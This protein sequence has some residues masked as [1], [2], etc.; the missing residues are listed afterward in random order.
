MPTSPSSFAPSLNHWYVGSGQASPSHVS[1]IRG[2]ISLSWGPGSMKTDRG[3]VTT[4]GVYSFA[5]SHRMPDS[6]TPSDELQF[7]LMRRR[8]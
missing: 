3:C 1:V 4:L 6:V 2:V 5:R 7:L 8:Q